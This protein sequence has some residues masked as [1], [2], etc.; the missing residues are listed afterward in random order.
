MNT[1]HTSVFREHRGKGI[2]VALKLL[3]IGTALR[4]GAPAL[5]TN[6]DSRNTGVLCVNSKLGFEPMSG[7]YYA[8]RTA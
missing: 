3:S 4:Y 7:V 1:W 2:T 5:V 8:Q 6:N